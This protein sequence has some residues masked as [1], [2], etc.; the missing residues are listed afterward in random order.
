MSFLHGVKM[1]AAGL[2]WITLAAG[3]PA[4]A[5]ERSSPIPAQVHREAVDHLYNLEFEDA[6]GK[7]HLRTTLEPDLPA[8]YTFLAYAL[9]LRE[10]DR[11]GALKRSVCSETRYLLGPRPK[12][13]DPA[14]AKAF[15]EVAG[16]GISVGQERLRRDP[17][18]IEGLHGLAVM[19]TLLS[20]YTLQFRKKAGAGLNQAKKAKRYGRRAVLQD[21]QFFDGYLVT[22]L[23]D[24][25]IGSMP[26]LVKFLLFFKGARGNK[27]LG[28]L[29]VRAS[30]L[31]GTSTKTEAQI[32]LGVLLS[33]EKEWKEVK[34]LLEDFEQRFPRNYYFPLIRAEIAEKQDQLPE[35]LEIYEAVLEKVREGAP[36]YRTAPVSRVRYQ[37][38][39]LYFRQ[40]RKEKS[41]SH[42][43]R[44][45]EEPEASSV[46][47][48]EATPKDS[49]VLKELKKMAQR[50][51][52]K[53]LSPVS[54]TPETA[55]PKVPAGS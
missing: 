44:I 4:G 7:F 21:P 5:A 48:G 12:K 1:S 55:R 30:A 6:I 45:L 54:S 24:Y 49:K 36:G 38:A 28:L 42:L 26:P 32:L 18:D 14:F 47:A 3:F 27:K 37:A 9:M 20:L 11:R 19:H 13:P 35:A 22:G 50:R 52:K 2:L 17:E 10:I 29:A 25:A 51:R 39:S 15:L 8:S 16:K 34:E 33:R 53:I 31:H 43:D 41:I 40:G 23:Y 46:D